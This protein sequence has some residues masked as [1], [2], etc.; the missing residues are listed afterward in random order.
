[1]NELDI[2][3]VDLVFAYSTKYATEG[4]I[5]LSELSRKLTQLKQGAKV[6]TIDKRLRGP[7]SLIST[8]EDPNGDLQLSTGYVWKRQ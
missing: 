7:F 4:G 2:S 8:L 1:D 6:I 5:Y 3:D